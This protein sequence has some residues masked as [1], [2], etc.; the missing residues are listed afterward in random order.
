MEDRGAIR[1]STHHLRTQSVTGQIRYKEPSTC[2]KAACCWGPS[3]MGIVFRECFQPLPFI[4][5][6]RPFRLTFWGQMLF[7]GR[8]FSDKRFY[9]ANPKDPIFAREL[10]PTQVGQ[11]SPLGN[12]ASPSG[13]THQPAAVVAY[14]ASNLGSVLPK[15]RSSTTGSMIHE[16]GP[17]RWMGSGMH[18]RHRARCWRRL[19][20]GF[21]KP[22][23]MPMP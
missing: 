15:M 13:T 12:V 20:P 16:P 14:P 2:R 18:E 10:F 19:P 9:V 11:S 8:R 3:R 22:M 5:P 7:V 4:Y 17:S 6:P 1:E 23:P 21:W